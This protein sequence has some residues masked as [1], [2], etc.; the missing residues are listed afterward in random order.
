MKASNF[1]EVAGK[2]R[3][4]T[5]AFAALVSA[6]A[7][8]A[9][10]YLYVRDRRPRLRVNANNTRFH[11]DDGTL[12]ARSSDFARRHFYMFNEG[13]RPVKVEEVRVEF[14]GKTEDGL[15]IRGMCLDVDTERHGG[16]SIGPISHLTN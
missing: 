10:L 8:T 13:N 1:A 16:H 14:D 7:A 4:A 3:Q 11:R 9:T 6:A 5:P 15:P 12:V 2:V